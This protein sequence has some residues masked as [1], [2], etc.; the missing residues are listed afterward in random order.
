MVPRSISRSDIGLTPLSY[1]AGNGHKA[2][3]QLLLEN[4]AEIE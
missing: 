2:T 1:A 3:V 4:G